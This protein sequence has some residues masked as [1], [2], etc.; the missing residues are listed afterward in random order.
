MAINFCLQTRQSTGQWLCNPSIAQTKVSTSSHIN[1]HQILFLVLSLLKGTLHL[2]PVFLFKPNKENS[3]IEK[4]TCF[5]FPDLSSRDWVLLHLQERIWREAS[6][7]QSPCVSVLTLSFNHTR[8]NFT[9]QSLQVLKHK[10]IIPA[11]MWK[12]DCTSKQTW[13]FL[14]GSLSWVSARQM[15]LLYQGSVMLLVVLNTCS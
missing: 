10:H 2:G 3:L 15:S 8:P 6:F 1:Q 13:D 11:G 12:G 9:C 14:E 5:N 7:G 4:V